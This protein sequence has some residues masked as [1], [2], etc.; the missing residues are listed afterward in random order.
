MNATP[1][2]TEGVCGCPQVICHLEIYVWQSVCVC[3][4]DIETFREVVAEWFTVPAWGR[5][6]VYA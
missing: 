4:W 3:V 2:R 6:H 1:A 5:T